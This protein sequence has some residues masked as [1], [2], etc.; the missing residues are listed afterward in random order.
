MNLDY[1]YYILWDLDL[2][3]L[4]LQIWILIVIYL[5][6]SEPENLMSGYKE[7]SES[8]FQ[9]KISY[10]RVF[11]LNQYWLSSNL[12]GL[13]ISEAKYFLNIYIKICSIQICCLGNHS[14]N[15]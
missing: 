13:V 3:I 5:I 4:G 8:K 14:E 11:F 7:L 12:S 1:S 6:G 2:K 15:G 10:I 9:S